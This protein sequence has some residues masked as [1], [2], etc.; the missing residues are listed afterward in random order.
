MT[1]FAKPPATLAEQLSLW[2]SRGLVIADLER[3]RHY[4]SVISYYRFSAYTLPLQQ[5][6]PDHHFRTGTTFEDILA[7]YIFDRRLR[8]L[9]LDSIERIEVALRAVLTN[10]LAE[11]HGSHA[12]LKPEIFDTRYNHAWLLQKIRDKCADSQAETF[13]KH[14]RNKYSEPPLPPVWMCIE[15][16]TFKEVSVL[17]AQLSQREDK[18]AIASFWGIPDTVLASWFRAVSDL[19]NIC[20]HHARTWNR[21]FG[22]RPMVPKKRPAKWPDF[23]RPLTDSRVDPLRRLYFLLAVTQFLLIRVNPGSTWHIRLRE[24]LRLYPNISK[25]HMGMPENW[26]H[27]P[28]WNFTD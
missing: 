23:S 3:A 25:A 22:S 15:V 19:R 18:Q 17:F 20:A 1:L 9:L 21:E 28:F 6:D 27:D 11:H 5:G 4:L 24:L 10:V 26:E 14:Y 2:E 7:V 16:L 12:Y 8:L 13:I